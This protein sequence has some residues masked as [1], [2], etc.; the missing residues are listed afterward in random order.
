MPVDVPTRFI[1]AIAD[2]AG[3]RV[4]LNN[5]SS[6]DLARLPVQ[7]RQRAVFSARA[8]NARH[9]SELDSLIKRI[10]SPDEL[11][12]GTARGPGE[13]MNEARA[14]ELLRQVLAEEGYQP[15]PAEAGT[16]KDLSSEVRIRV[17]LQT[18]TGLA[19]GY[20]Q[21][22][23]GQDDDV[24]N[25]FP[26]WRLLP[27]VASSPRPDGY[28]RARWR[29]AGLPLP[30]G[31]LVALKSDPGWARL[32][33]FGLPYPPFDYGS[34]REVED[35]DRDEAEALGLV[36]AGDVLQGASKP[37][38]ADL[39]APLPET[40]EALQAAILA[41]MPGARIEAGVLVGL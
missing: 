7:I 32:S 36:T 27:S 16:L 8:S 13:Y 26:A 3:R 17:Q 19:F 15:D 2:R 9:V 6:E 10:V 5:L 41:S 21:W 24:L 31:Q 20:G 22:K 35:V 39:Q 25:E 30:Q 40:S 33:R 1:E 34:T 14:R 12:D 38:D 23:Q 4:L 28:W 29:E 37:F 11:P 18:S